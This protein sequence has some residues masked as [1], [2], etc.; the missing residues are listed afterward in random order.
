VAVI[1]NEPDQTPKKTESTSASA[2]ASKPTMTVAALARKLSL[3]DKKVEG[4]NRSEPIDLRSSPVPQALPISPIRRLRSSLGSRDD[5]DDFEILDYKLNG[6]ST[7]HDDDDDKNGDESQAFKKVKKAT[8]STSTAVTPLT[9]SQRNAASSSKLEVAQGPSKGKK[10]TGA[11]P[12]KKSVKPKTMSKKATL[13]E[14]AEFWAASQ[15]NLDARPKQ[16]KKTVSFDRDEDQVAVKTDQEMVDGVDKVDE[17]GPV[18]VA[19]I[20]TIPQP[21][22]EQQQLE[23]Q[24]PERQAGSPMP[25]LLVGI[26]DIAKII[27]LITALVPDVCPDHLDH[28]IR[29]Q[30][31]SNPTQTFASEDACAQVL[32]HLFDT[33]DAKYP[34]VQKCNL[35]RKAEEP[36]AGPSSRS[37]RRKYGPVSGEGNATG[38]DDRDDEYESDGM[39]GFMSEKARLGERKGWGYRKGV[40]KDLANLFPAMSMAQ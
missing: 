33:D 24:Q 3:A 39:V 25:K 23:Q 31:F 13:P 21:V 11:V 40:V 9:K 12:L 38:E 2:S 18:E 16:V 35:K 32:A 36:E 30:I 6:V 22:P 8:A 4:R 29:T 10:D 14:E 19:S 1:N 17:L 26:D 15:L 7:E 27:S 5:E 37:K 34:K 20:V 28:V